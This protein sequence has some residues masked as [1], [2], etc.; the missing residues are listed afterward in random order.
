VKARLKR[1]VQ[2]IEKNTGISLEFLMPV[3]RLLRR[4]HIRRE[5]RIIDQEM[6]PGSTFVHLLHSLHYSRIRW[7]R[8]MPKARKIVDLGGASAGFP[9]GALVQMGYLYDF[10]SLTIVDL[11]LEERHAIYQEGHQVYRE[12]LQYRS[13]TI[14]YY[15]TPM[16]QL[17][18]IK[19]GSI[20][21][22]NSG[23]SI[24]HITEQE[25]DVMLKE[26]LRILKPGGFFCLDTPNGR[27][28][29]LQQESMIDPDHKIEYTEPELTKKIR[30]AGFQ[31]LEKKGLNWLPESFA[32]QHFDKDEVTRNF[33]IYDDIQNCYL[34]AYRCQKPIKKP[35]K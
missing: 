21:F 24:E 15:Y 1:I 26:C 25:G 11:P 8:G 19:T 32:N 34:L 5:L 17:A 12:K 23:Q 20:D 14:D 4:H 33:G 31:I 10:D 27:A 3:W 28:T 9:P 6:H 30:H 13:G 2:K 35:L 22:I 16:Y 7:V 29:R 18:K